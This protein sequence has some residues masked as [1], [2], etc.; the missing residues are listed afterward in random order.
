MDKWIKRGIVI[1]KVFIGWVTVGRIVCFINSM[2]L[3]DGVVLD[4]VESISG[5]QMQFGEV[6]FQNFRG[7]MVD[8][9]RGLASISIEKVDHLDHPFFRKG[10][11]QC[12][13]AFK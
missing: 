4:N 10:D 8:G 12:C 11:S 1:V 9:R 13:A 5:D 7:L 6:I 2:V 3:Q